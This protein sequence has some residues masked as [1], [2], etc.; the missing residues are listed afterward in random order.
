MKQYSTFGMLCIIL[1]LG[2]L[3]KQSRTLNSNVIRPEPLSCKAISSVEVQPIQKVSV[4]PKNSAIP[5]AVLAP[6]E[7]ENLFVK[8]ASEYEVTSNTLKILANCESKFNSSALSANG[9]YG[10]LF[11]YSQG[12]WIST[13]KA[14][15][16]DENPE[17]RFNAEEAIKTTA[18]KIANGGIGAWTHCGNKTQTQL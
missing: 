16:L 8:Y 17:L 18:F 12:T 4:S 6:A 15:G 14:M 2:L 5:V 7:L 9:L 1:T 13:R 11:Q 10:G 3:I